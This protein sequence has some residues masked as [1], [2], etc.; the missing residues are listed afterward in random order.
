[1]KVFTLYYTLNDELIQ[2]RRY[3]EVHGGAKVRQNCPKPM[4][5]SSQ[6]CNIRDVVKKDGALKFQFYKLSGMNFNWLNCFLL[7]KLKID[8]KLSLQYHL[9]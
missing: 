4:A 5:L 3:G 6:A 2:S 8:M 9:K 7:H 1:M